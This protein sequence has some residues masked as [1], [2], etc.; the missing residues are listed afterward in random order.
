MGT[1]A[2]DD[3]RANGEYIT[4]SQQDQDELRHVSVE[5]PC[6]YLHG[7]G[8]RSEAYLVEQLDGELYERLL[9]RGFRR[10]GRVVYR[11]QCSG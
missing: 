11:P 8:A 5:A 6:P 10:S 3:M 9:G 7:N 2:T 4:S 1:E